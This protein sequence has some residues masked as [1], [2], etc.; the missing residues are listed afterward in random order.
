VPVGLAAGA[1]AGLGYASGIE[2]R[3]FRLRHVTAPVLPPGAPP[4]RVLQI[5]DVHLCP[6]QRRKAAW[7][8]SLAELKPDLVIDTGD[9]IAHPDAVPV[10]LLALEPLLGVPGLFVWGSNDY[11]APIFKSPAR[12]LRPDDGRR[13]FGKTLPWRD[14]GAA[15][16][17]AGWCDLTHTRVRLSVAGLDVEAAGVDDPHLGHDRYDRIAGRV[18]PDADLAVGVAHS[19]EPRVLD[20]FVSDGFQLLVAGHTH[21]GQLRLPG[22]GALVTNCGL[23]RHR[24]RG[25]SRYDGAQLHVSAGL[26]TSP[27]A[28]FRFACPPEASLLTLVAR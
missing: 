14:L 21:G 27:Y 25:L 16:T 28:P 22:Y 17:G 24:A 20:R 13:H 2:L 6:W 19:P 12:Y 1:A 18:S 3:A 8:R 7:I 15:L 4:V 23:D 5:S 10:M 11:F 9:N 26:G